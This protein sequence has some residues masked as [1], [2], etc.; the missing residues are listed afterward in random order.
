MFSAGQSGQWYFSDD[1]TR[2]VFLQ[3]VQAPISTIVHV[4]NVDGPGGSQAIATIT[5]MGPSYEVTAFHPSSSRVL[6]SGS[7]GLFDVD[8]SQSEPVVRVATTSLAARYCNCA[9][10]DSS[11]EFV[12]Y[13][14][15]PVGQ[16][17]PTGIWR[18][19]RSLPTNQAVVVPM[20]PFF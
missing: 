13:P 4:A 18:A 11:G 10:Y 20:V 6:V 3:S 2:L 5:G 17:N 9:R 19:N 15:V 1:G 16:S 14:G 7:N 12:T 8:L